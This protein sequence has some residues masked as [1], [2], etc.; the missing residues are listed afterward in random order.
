DTS[1]LKENCKTLWQLR[2]EVEM[3]VLLKGMVAHAEKTKEIGLDVIAGSTSLQ[4]CHHRRAG[5]LK[6]QLELSVKAARRAD[7]LSDV[8]Q[9]VGEYVSFSEALLQLALTAVLEGLLKNDPPAAAE[10]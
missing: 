5:E 10:V 3:L 6:M 7:S 1:A 8:V 2:A 4:P 9:A